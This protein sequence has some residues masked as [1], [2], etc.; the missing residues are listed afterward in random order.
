MIVLFSKVSNSLLELMISTWDRISP[1]PGVST[2]VVIKKKKSSNA[3]GN[4]ASCEI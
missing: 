4:N 2:K 1:F 3:Q